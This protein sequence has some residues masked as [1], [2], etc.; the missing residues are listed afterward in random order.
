MTRRD[1]IASGVAAATVD[2]T[3]RLQLS[4]VGRVLPPWRKGE[5]DIHFIHTGVGE[6]TFFIFPDGTTMLLDCG[7]TH[8]E[9]Y[10]RD[11]PPSPDGTRYGGEWVSR[12]IQRLISH[13]EID[14]AMVSHWH[15]DHTGDL[16]F[17]GKRTTDGRI[18]CGL[19]LVGE[20]FFFRHYFDHQYP[21]IGEHACDPDKGALKLMREWIPRTVADG[22]RAHR[23]E[24]GSDD[25]ICLLHDA[26][27]F[28]QF[29]VRNIAANGAVWDGVG[30]VVDAAATHVKRTGV[31]AIHENRLSSAIRIQYGRFSYYSGGDNE[32]TMVGADGREFSWEGMVGRAAGPVDV[33]KTNHHAGVFGMR[34]EFIREV[35]AKAYL[36]SVWQAG[37]VDHKSLSTMCSRELYPGDRIVCF[38]DIA[39][40]RRNVADAYDGVVQP[41]GHAVVRVAPG[42]DTF[43]VFTLSTMD[44]R[45][46]V[47]SER[48]FRSRG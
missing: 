47:L 32:L 38:G 29:R 6:Q 11:V 28:P 21:K 45:M 22:M 30:G 40:G 23:F 31:D 27:A 36:S 19:P 1:F 46:T 44:E 26:A 9:K 37:M 17:G 43:R 8:H 10:M 33:C 16:A 35:R 4:C 20:D 42:G 14:Y 25:Q 5:L 39:D 41:P 7:D 12:Y 24:V 3:E 34:P 13:R 15:G 48:S 18:V 2:S